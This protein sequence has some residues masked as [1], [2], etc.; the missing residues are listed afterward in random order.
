MESSN[1][2]AHFLWK[3]ILRVVPG[4]LLSIAVVAVIA[5]LQAVSPT[6]I[7]WATF[8]VG[9]RGESAN[10]VLWSLSVEEVL[11]VLL[12]LGFAINVF[13]TGRRSL[14]ALAVGASVISVILPLENP[15][16]TAAL[17]PP[18]VFLFAVAFYRY[19]SAIPWNAWVAALCLLTISLAMHFVPDVLNL[20]GALLPFSAALVYGVI[21]LGL[22]AKPLLARFESIGDPSYGIYILHYP[23]LL[24]IWQLGLH[25]LYLY[26]VA[27][28]AAV[29]MGLLSY[30]LLERH[31]LKF[32]NSL[33]EA[34][35]P[36][37]EAH[38]EGAL[39]TGPT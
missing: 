20:K 29:M 36:G 1:S 35:S 16:M 34:T 24:Y 31:A 18:I 12:A 22:Y 39:T 28:L 15:Y 17:Q 25:S 10:P 11:Y 30:H 2:Y 32:K 5:G 21:G 26:P 7:C 27:L 9:R 14:A 3:R 4:F 23:V 6:L 38:L 13:T 8:G 19:R 33:F 37:A